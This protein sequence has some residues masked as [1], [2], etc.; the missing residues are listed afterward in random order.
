MKPCRTCG[1]EFDAHRR[2]LYCSADCRCAKRLSTFWEGV[3]VGADTVCW[4]W[5]RAVHRQGYGWFWSGAAMRLAHAVALELALGRRLKKLALHTCDNPVCC[6]PRH[7]YEGDQVQNMADM[8]ARGREV[9][10][11]GTHHGRYRHGAYAR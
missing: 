3:E 8:R 4:P 6:N 1:A 11:K 5:K 2:A 7:L 9:K 10:A